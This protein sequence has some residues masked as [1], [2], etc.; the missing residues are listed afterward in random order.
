MNTLIVVVHVIVCV[1]LI[2]IVLLQQGKGADMGAAFGGSSQTIFG[3]SG[4]GNFLEKLTT[5]AAILFMITSLSLAYISL[6]KPG[7]S[8]FK[9]TPPRVQEKLPAHESPPVP[10]PVE[11]N[12]PG[13]GPK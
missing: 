6:K 12:I 5:G 11:E 3:S 1:L 9:N 2:L 10:N 13:P 7:A 8:V 4:P